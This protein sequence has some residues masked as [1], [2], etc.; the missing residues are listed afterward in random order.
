M[1]LRALGDHV[2]VLRDAVKGTSDGGLVLP[3]AKNP[4]KGLEYGEVMEVGPGN[5]VDITTVGSGYTKLSVRRGQRVLFTAKKAVPI[6]NPEKQDLVV[7][8]EEDI[9]AVVD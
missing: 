3:P 4:H 5:Y 9:V 8:R 2:I 6:T 7:L 1:N